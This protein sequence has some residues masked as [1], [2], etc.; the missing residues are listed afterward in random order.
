MRR[1]S[2]SEILRVK[3]LSIPHRKHAPTIPNAPTDIP[4]CPGVQD[5]R[6]P[7]RVITTRAAKIRRL[8]GSLN[9]AK[10][11]NA[12]AADSKLSRIEAVEA[13]VSR[14]P[15]SRTMGAAT[16]PAITAPISQGIS[17]LLIFERLAGLFFGF[18]KKSKLNDPI[19]LPRYKNAAKGIGAIS[20]SNN[21]D[22]G[23]DIPNKIAA[24][25]ARKMGLID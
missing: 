20:L 15:K 1:G 12:V 7:A 3:L 16:P 13:G 2:F 4:H 22:S 18:N 25:R 24:K 14:R 21:L 17:E 19:P 23:A 6:T 5:K 10:A 8:I 11:I 9:T